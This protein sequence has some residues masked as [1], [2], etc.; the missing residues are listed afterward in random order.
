MVVQD[1]IINRFIEQAYLDP[2]DDAVIDDLIEEFW[3]I[4]ETGS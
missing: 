1:E 2:M 3:G 4:L